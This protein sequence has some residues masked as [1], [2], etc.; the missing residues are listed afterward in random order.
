MRRWSLPLLLVALLA[1]SGCVTVH[2]APTRPAGASPVAV[3]EDRKHPVDPRP[4]RPDTGVALLVS[5]MLESAAAP[6][7]GDA[8]PEAGRPRPGPP[9]APLPSP[10]PGR[11]R[12]R[13]V[14]PHRTARYAPQER[15]AA[16]MTELRRA[17]HGV[18]SPAVAAPCHQTYV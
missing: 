3:A 12:G 13:G 14:R 15:G 2:P 4:A 10:S 5:P 7:A 18:A 8:V 16:D 11:R 6:P 1:A 9:C 17:A